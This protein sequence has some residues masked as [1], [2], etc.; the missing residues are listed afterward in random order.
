[1][2]SVM[3]F[4]HTYL[5]EAQ[6]LL[7]KANEILTEGVSQTEKDKNMTQAKTYMVMAETIEALVLQKPTVQA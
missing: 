4:E 2:P 3:N 1:M 6:E 5:S 7:K